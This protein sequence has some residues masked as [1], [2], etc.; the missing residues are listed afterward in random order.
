MEYVRRL[1]DF[2][3]KLRE[4]TGEESYWRALEQF[5][6]LDPSTLR[7]MALQRYA[8]SNLSE[9]ERV[10]KGLEVLIGKQSDSVNIL[11]RN[12]V[13][14]GEA[15]SWRQV[16]EN[17]GVLDHALHLC[18]PE[19]ETT[20]MLEFLSRRARTVGKIFCLWHGERASVMKNTL[21]KLGYGKMLETGKIVILPFE[22]TRDTMIREGHV[23]TATRKFEQ[24][25]DEAQEAEY[26]EFSL[27]GS[28]GGSLFRGG[29]YDLARDWEAFLHRNV[30][31]RK[32]AIYCPYPILS[33][34]LNPEALE[35]VARVHNWVADDTQAYRLDLA[36]PY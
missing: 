27:G 22:K 28:L 4:R 24:L 9:K 29:Y 10:E 35:K 36:S 6:G 26:P 20:G 1:D 8:D 7:L 12:V 5:F 11:A 30:Y 32:G 25:F 18:T 31:G 15:T 34:P 3:E 19:E 14:V 23:G 16:A 2:V 33:D 13:P 17:I 21:V